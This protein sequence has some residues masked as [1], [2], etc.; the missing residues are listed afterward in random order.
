MTFVAIHIQNQIT[1]KRCGP[2]MARK[3]FRCPRWRKKL[4]A[5]LGD[6]P[7]PTSASSPSPTPAACNGFDDAV[8]RADASANWAS[9]ASQLP[10]PEMNSPKSPSGCRQI[11]LLL[12]SS[13]GAARSPTPPMATGWSNG[14]PHPH[15]PRNPTRR[16]PRHAH[17]A[18]HAQ[19]RRHDGIHRRSADEEDSKYRD[20]VVPGR[21]ERSSGTIWL[22]KPEK[23]DQLARSRGSLLR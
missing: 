3:L 4:E 22:G 13:K 7:I 11:A 1:P 19:T 9:S 8:K 15:R 20:K 16:H 14:L 5:A 18:E 10:S 6:A 21:S 2:W 12:N 17:G 23:I